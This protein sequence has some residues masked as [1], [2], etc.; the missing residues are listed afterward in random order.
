MEHVIAEKNPLQSSEMPSFA[1]LTSSC[2]RYTNFSQANN[3]YKIFI[4]L[5]QLKGFAGVTHTR[6]KNQIMHILDTGNLQIISAFTLDGHLARR[7][8]QHVKSNL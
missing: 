2:I 5:A 1:G 6:K 8:G 7:E 3:F 4:K